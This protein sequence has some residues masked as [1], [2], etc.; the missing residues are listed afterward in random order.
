VTIMLVPGERSRHFQ[1][2]PMSWS[3]PVPENRQ[4]PRTQM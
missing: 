4:R 3:P 2:K 1:P